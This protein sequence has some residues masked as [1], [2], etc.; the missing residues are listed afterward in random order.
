VVDAVTH[1]REQILKIAE[2][3]E[4]DKIG[5][6]SVC[7]KG[8]IFGKQILENSFKMNELIIIDECGKMELEDK[9]W[10]DFLKK[11]NETPDKK[12]I[13]TIRDINVNDFIEKYC[14]ENYLVVDVKKS[15]L[16]KICEIISGS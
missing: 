1:E 4:C 16:E 3:D 7:K 12:F 9:G 5:K 13:L 15:E 10:A 2:C 14:W 6:Y 11:I 8:F